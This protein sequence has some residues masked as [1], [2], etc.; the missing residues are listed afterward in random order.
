MAISDQLRA[1]IQAQDV[2]LYRIAK[3]SDVDWGTLQRFLDGTRPNIHIETV[4]KLC[5]YFGLELQPK[6]ISRKKKYN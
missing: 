5:E 1:E 2:T 3:D 6:K 4:E